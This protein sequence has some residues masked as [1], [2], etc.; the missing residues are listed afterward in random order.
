MQILKQTPRE[1]L[2]KVPQGFN[3]NMWWNMAHVVV[4][5][6]MLLYSLSNLP[7]ATS[8]SL[9]A[10]YRK[11][12]YPDGI[13]SESEIREVEG[14]MLSLAEK[15]SED[16]KKGVF[17]TFNEYTT[18]VGVTLRNFEDALSFNTFHEGLHLGVIMS[19]K[20]VV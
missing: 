12:T 13:P 7:M 18:S 5:Q 20:K 19:L 14:L 10:K 11:G 3:N 1:Q 8:D 6:Q 2:F 17:K 9:V 4:T 16:Y 15:T